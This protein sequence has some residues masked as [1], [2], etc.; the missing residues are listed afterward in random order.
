[1]LLFSVIN[2]VLVVMVTAVVAVADVVG[3]G[4]FVADAIV[5]KFGVVAAIVD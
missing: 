2:I 3:V 4:A 5:D 1:M